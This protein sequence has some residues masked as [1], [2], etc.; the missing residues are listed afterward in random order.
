[1]S[2]TISPSDLLTDIVVADNDY[3][4]PDAIGAGRAI[5]FAGLTPNQFEDTEQALV[6]SLERAMGAIVLA[7][8]ALLAAGMLRGAVAGAAARDAAIACL[9]V[10]IAAGIVAALSA[11]RSAM[12]VGRLT[13]AK[14]PDLYPVDARAPLSDPVQ[15]HRAQA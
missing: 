9:V 5:R 11:V 6:D 8:V 14:A 7:G 1:M 4:S 12:T 10:A 13:R 3:P 15:R 2:L